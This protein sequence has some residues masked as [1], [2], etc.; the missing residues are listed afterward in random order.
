MTSAP[1][2]TNPRT[3]NTR[4]IVSPD[5]ARKMRPNTPLI[6]GILPFIATVGFFLWNPDYY[7]GVM[8]DPAFLP[9]VGGGLA[10]MTA[11]IYMLNRMVNF[12]V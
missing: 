5:T 3:N 6:P 4:H 1:P 8:D 12:R 9:V 2:K 11:G 7:L 10:L